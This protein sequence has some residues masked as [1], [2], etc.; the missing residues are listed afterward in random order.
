M[1]YKLTLQLTYEDEP[2]FGPGPMR[3]AELIEGGYSLRQAALAMGMSYSK[4]WRIL[5][6][7]EKAFG[8]PLVASQ[9]GGAGGG[10]SALTSEGERVLKKYREFQDRARK[11]CDQ[12]FARYFND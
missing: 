8:F 6:G 2:V 1:Q 11:Q 12:L 9:R 10:G 3:L 5:G 7:F 4:A